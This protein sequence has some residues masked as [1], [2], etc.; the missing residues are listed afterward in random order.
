MKTQLLRHVDGL[1]RS[2]RYCENHFGISIVCRE[3]S[4]G[5]KFTGLTL[6][7]IFVFEYDRLQQLSVS[8]EVIMTILEIPPVRCFK[9]KLLNTFILGATNAGDQGIDANS[10]ARIANCAISFKT[11]QRLLLLFQ[12]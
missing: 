10:Y 2:I 7:V 3:R 4:A 11:K 8:Y 9:Q 6:G 1:C 12:S 5:E